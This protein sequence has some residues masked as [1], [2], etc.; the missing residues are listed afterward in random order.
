MNM[1]TLNGARDRMD[2]NCIAAAGAGVKNDIANMATT[3][4]TMDLV[5]IAHRDRQKKEIADTGS[6]TDNLSFVV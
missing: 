2:G 5:I 6:S 1:T 3:T 4:V